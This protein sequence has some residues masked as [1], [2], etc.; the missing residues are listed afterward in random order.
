MYEM[1]STNLEDYSHVRVQKITKFNDSTNSRTKA[2]H[3]VETKKGKSSYNGPP[4][5]KI[6]MLDLLVRCKNPDFFWNLRL[7]VYVL[8][9]LEI[10]FCTLK[11]FQ[12]RFLE[13]Q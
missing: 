7:P 4:G 2:H 9:E 6:Q 3:R 11:I 13:C 8:V 10:T 1:R 12:L 5:L